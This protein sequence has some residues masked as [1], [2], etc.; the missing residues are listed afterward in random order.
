[1][2]AGEAG[3]SWIPAFIFD[4]ELVRGPMDVNIMVEKV[5]AIRNKK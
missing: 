2:L 4:E 3:I 5:Q 1:M